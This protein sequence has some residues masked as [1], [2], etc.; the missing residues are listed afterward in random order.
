MTDAPSQQELEARVERLQALRD[1]ITAV[2]T[3]GDKKL[4]GAEFADAFVK[5]YAALRRQANPRDADPLSQLREDLLLAT[6]GSTPE[7]RDVGLYN[8]TQELR[9]SA[10]VTPDAI[11]AELGKVR[12]I[13]GTPSPVKPERTKPDP[14]PLTKAREAA[15]SAAI[16]N[17]R[18]D[19]NLT[20]ENEKAI[21][22]MFGLSTQTPEDVAQNR[23]LEGVIGGLRT[24]LSG[25]K[26]SDVGAPPNAQELLAAVN[27]AE[28]TN[29]RGGR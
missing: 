5:Q 19:G 18:K 9:A 28:P 6:Q 27:R 3:N 16:E 10:L 20:P 23:R 25:Y 22:G 29:G 1:A 21:R 13:A 2:D 14:E 11:R 12:D 17:A 24:Q 7:E 15:A 4:S 26:Q 8:V